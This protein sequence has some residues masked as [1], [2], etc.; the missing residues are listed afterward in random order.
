M[1]GKYFI[2]DVL[3][4]TEIKESAACEIEDKL[5]MNG[6]KCSVIWKKKDNTFFIYDENT[7]YLHKGIK[8]G[9]VICILNLYLDK[10]QLSII[11]IYRGKDC[12]WVPN[13]H[14][15]YF[16]ILN[17]KGEVTSKTRYSWYLNHELDIAMGNCF[18][19]K[20]EAE[21]NKGIIME[22]YKSIFEYA[23]DLNNE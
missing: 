10:G 1:M 6:C 5:K 17:K 3:L 22:R 13:D 19:T 23:N 11:S 21:K 15:E 12:K 18:K 14:E 4:I 2:K 9:D 16:C 7:R 8:K 20:E